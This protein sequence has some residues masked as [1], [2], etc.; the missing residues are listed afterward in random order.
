MLLVKALLPI[1]ILLSPGL[2]L[3][4]IFCVVPPIFKDNVP[5]PMAILLFPL[6]T[7]NGD[8][9]S[10]LLVSEG[11]PIAILPLMPEPPPF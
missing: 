8:V 4:R 5:E 10:G 7:A 11:P 1:A 2:V 3:S 6:F 9:A